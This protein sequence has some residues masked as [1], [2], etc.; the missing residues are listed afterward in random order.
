M[1]LEIPE[2]IEN[3][4]REKGGWENIK[5]SL[6]FKEMEE[7]EKIGKTLSSDIRLKMLYYLYLQRMC[8]CMLTDLTGC[9]YSKCSYH[10]SMLKKTGLIESTRSGNYLIYSL[11]PF[12]KSIIQHFKKYKPMLKK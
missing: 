5:R 11:T 6:P 10:I 2:E 4:L 7:V 3:E 12:G 1:K 8:V 9:T